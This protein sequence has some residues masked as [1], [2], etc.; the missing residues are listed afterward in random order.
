MKQLDVVEF[1]RRCAAKRTR[2]ADSRLAKNGACASTASILPTTA[3]Q[4]S[5]RVFRLMKEIQQL[6]K[7]MEQT[8]GRAVDEFS[9]RSWASSSATGPDIGTVPLYVRQKFSIHS[10]IYSI[11]LDF[12]ERF[13][14]Y[15]RSVSGYSRAVLW[16][17]WRSVGSGVPFCEYKKEWNGW[18]HSV[19][20]S[21]C[22]QEAVAAV[23][24]KGM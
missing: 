9:R 20:T 12:A 1:V 16:M 17:G 21:T 11:A 22:A 15:A 14:L 7:M 19:C 2:T 23:H 8:A 18:S 10:F 6:Q 13:V 24:G 3:Q 4:A 5:Q